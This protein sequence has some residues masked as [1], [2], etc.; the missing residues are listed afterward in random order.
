[1][2]RDQ[3]SAGISRTKLFFIFILI[4]GAGVVFAG[5]FNVGLS[6]TNTM[7][8]CTDCHSMKINLE[9]LQETVHY[10]NNS[11]LPLLIH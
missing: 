9:E 1:M 10:K 5:L 3:K 8:F 11:S 7:E 2:A 4:F 6:A